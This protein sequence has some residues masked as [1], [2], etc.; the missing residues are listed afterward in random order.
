MKNTEIKFR[1]WDGLLEKSLDFNPLCHFFNDETLIFQQ[2]TGLKDKN[3]K[4]IYEGDWLKGQDYELPVQAVFENGQFALA[5]S[6][7]NSSLEACYSAPNK[8]I[9]MTIVGNIFENPELLK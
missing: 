1:V 9:G 3:G 7:M 6:N 5:Y 4:E 8:T 2:F